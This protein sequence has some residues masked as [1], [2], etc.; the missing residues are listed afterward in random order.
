[1]NKNLFLLLLMTIVGC[2]PV[3]KVT[4]NE[5]FIEEN[6][7]NYIGSIAVADSFLQGNC[8]VFLPNYKKDWPDINQAMYEFKNVLTSEYIANR[9]YVQRNLIEKQVIEEIFGGQFET[10]LNKIKVKFRLVDGSREECLRLFQNVSMHLTI[11]K[12]QWNLFRDNSYWGQA[13]NEYKK[14]AIKNHQ[15][16]PRLLGEDVVPKLTFD[17]LQEGFQ[18]IDYFRKQRDVGLISQQE[19][20]VRRS[21]IISTLY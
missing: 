2:A 10:S 3:T 9:P 14:E 12:W 18:R 13:I 8:A 1:M 4:S 17:Q 16:K 5:Y 7:G 20:E 6:G 15:N 21:K 19:F 11:V